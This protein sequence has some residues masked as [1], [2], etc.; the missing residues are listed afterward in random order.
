[1]PKPTT[2]TRQEL[3]SRFVTNAIPTEGDYADLIAA[4]LNQADDGILKLPDQSLG[5]V[6]QRPES[7][8]LRFFADPAAETS[9]WQLQLIGT[10]TP[11][12]GLSGP[13]GAAALFLDGTTEH[14]GIGT[15]SPG[16]R[17]TVEGRGPDSQATGNKLSKRGGLAIRSTTP[18]LDFIAMDPTTKDWAIQVKNNKLSLI[19]SPWESKD[20]VLDGSGKMGIGT[21]NPSHKLHVAGGLRVENNLTVKGDM[22]VSSGFRGQIRSVWFVS[23][24]PKNE[25]GYFGRIP[26]RTLKVKKELND[27]VLR[28]LYSDNTRIGGNTSAA[29]GARWEI[30][31]DGKSL[32]P[33]LSMDRMET[34]DLHFRIHTLFVGY[35]RLAACTYEIQVW[36]GEI[37]GEPSFPEHMTTGWNNSTWCLEVE[38]IPESDVIP[39]KS[40]LSSP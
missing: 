27:T 15:T 22:K 14:I 5:L 13:S 25:G 10:E 34:G 26:S 2:K 32:N 37:P 31:I 40:R 38:E 39:A 1:M 17:L 6:R 8:L 12:L 20:L 23:G 18:Q 35:A 21:D 28:I 19:R 3:R 7:P 36:V 33:P 11:G 30:R 9:A 16:H 24:P 4:G 29:S